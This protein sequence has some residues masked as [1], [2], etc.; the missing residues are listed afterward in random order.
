MSKLKGF[1][2]LG[3]IIVVAVI[4]VV[5]AIIL[6]GFGGLGFGGG[7]GDGEGDGDSTV[8]EVSQDEPE[9]TAVTEETEETTEEA[10]PVIETV[11]YI[12]ITVSENEYL[13][14]NNKYSLEE[15]IIELDSLPDGIPVK[16]TDDNASLNAYR[17]LTE[18]L[19]EHK[20]K[21]IE[22]NMN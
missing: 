17:Q 4:A 3:V 6:F 8:A 13:Y 19:D 7:K 22:E 5:A 10:V 12:N 2:V 18:A 20:I 15:L 16:L 1:S 9:E 14:Q 11:E 21:Y